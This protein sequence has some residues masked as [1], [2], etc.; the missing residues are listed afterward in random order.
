VLLVTM[1]FLGMTMFQPDFGTVVA[2]GLVILAMV[3]AGGANLLHLAGLVLLALPLGFAAIAAK[4][5]RMRRLLSFL[6][7]WADPQGAG[8]QI[9][10]SYLAFGSGGVFGRGWRGRQKLLFLP[11]AT[12]TSSTRDRRGAGPDRRSRVLVLFGIVLGRG[13]AIARH[14]EGFSRMLALGSRC[15]S[16]CRP[17]S[18]WRWSPGWCRRRASPCRS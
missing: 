11:S 14:T 6:D 12:R 1:V 2:M 10:Q 5:Y 3:L 7:P 16:A 8:H 9:V 18:T 4:A 15:S 13:I 17:C